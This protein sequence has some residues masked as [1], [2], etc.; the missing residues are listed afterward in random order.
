MTR[1]T[2]WIR[3]SDA[4]EGETG[5]LLVTRDWAGAHVAAVRCPC[6]GAAVEM[7]RYTKLTGEN[8]HADEC[9]ECGVQVRVLVEWRDAREVTA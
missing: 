8:G 4:P 3:E 2:R 5:A 7:G 9:P 1:M 6:C